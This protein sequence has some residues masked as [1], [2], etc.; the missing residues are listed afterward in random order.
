MHPP[1]LPAIDLGSINEAKVQTNRSFRPMKNKLNISVKKKS[2]HSN[3]HREAIKSSQNTT[4][5]PMHSLV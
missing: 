1:M 5:R 3:S 2:N 4:K